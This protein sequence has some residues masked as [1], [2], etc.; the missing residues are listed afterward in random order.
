MHYNKHTR[1]TG[2]NKMKEILKHDN[3]TKLLKKLFL[4]QMHKEAKN[5]NQHE[6][7]TLIK[8]I[9]KNYDDKN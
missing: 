6:Y 1:L 2:V 8:N 5:K 9:L 3:Q 4:D 7:A